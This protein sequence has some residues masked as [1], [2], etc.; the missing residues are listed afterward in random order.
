MVVINKIPQQSVYNLKPRPSTPPLSSH[1][2]PLQPLLKAL[3]TGPPLL[4]ELASCC[5]D[6]PLLV[7]HVLVVDAVL[8]RRL[9]FGGNLLTRCLGGVVLFIAALLLLLNFLKPLLPIVFILRVLRLIVWIEVGTEHIERVLGGREEQR[10]ELGVEPQLLHVLLALMEE[11][12][13]WRDVKATLSHLLFM[14]F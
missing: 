10:P 13:L 3:A 9:L 1:L 6:S 2:R 8:Y 7:L 14:L 4:I 5:D 11:E 12:E